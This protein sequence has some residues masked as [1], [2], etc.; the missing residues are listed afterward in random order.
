MNKHAGFS[1]SGR[2]A[3]T[4]VQW[5][6]GQWPLMLVSCEKQPSEEWIPDFDLKLV[7]KLLAFKA[8][9]K[10]KFFLWW[11]WVTKT[12]LVIRIIHITP[13]N[14]SYGIKHKFGCPN[15]HVSFV[16]ISFVNSTTSVLRKFQINSIIFPQYNLAC[17]IVP[18]F[19]RNTIGGQCWSA[20]PDQN[21]LIYM[22]WLWTWPTVER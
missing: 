4:K 14:Y 8:K 11:I 3:V 18:A 13:L 16:P 15:Q 5:A 17:K 1:R 6:V 2:K 10:I 12:Q 19:L 20:I 22:F 9:F 21:P 7:W